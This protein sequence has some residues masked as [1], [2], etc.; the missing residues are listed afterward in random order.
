MSPFG[1]A[2]AGRIR[3]GRGVAGEAASAARGYGRQV[4]LLR[5]GSVAW[6]DELVRDLA[7][8]GCEVS[9]LRSSGEPSVDDV[10]AAVAAGRGAD[11]VLGVGGG[12]VIDL[13][14]AAAA[15]IPSE[16]DV[17]EHL[18]VVGGGRPLQADPLPMIAIPTTAG[19]GA[20]VTKN[21]VIAVPEAARKV[22]LRDDRMLPRLALVDPALT[23]GAPRGVTLGSGLD[24]LV[25]VIEPYLSSKANPL[26]DALCR[27]AIPQGITALKRLAAGEDPAARDA[28]AYVSLSG[29]LALANA[30]L[31]AVHGLAGVIGGRFGAPHGLICG[32]LLGPVLAANADALGVSARFT[33]VQMWLSDG[34]DLPEEGTFDALTALLDDWGLERLNQWIPEDADLGETAREAAASSSMRANPCVLEA[35]TLEACIRAAM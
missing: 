31:G 22:S 4:L 12:A 29:G 18:E 25:Q 34:F 27:A 13:A 33:E 3:F 9:Q 32:R 17:M 5:G 15:L 20:E 6:V 11:V 14:K 8:A 1:F 2:T 35:E 21:A 7:A 30:G 16:C 28:L 10:R 19:T 23:D 24:A 26:T